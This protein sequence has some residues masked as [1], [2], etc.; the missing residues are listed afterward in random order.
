MGFMDGLESF[1][2]TFLPFRIVD[3][4]EGGVLLRRGKYRRTVGPGLYWTIPFIDSVIA[5]EITP[6]IKDIP[7]I[8][9]MWRGESYVVSGAVEYFIENPKKYA[10]E[11]Q[12]AD[13]TLKN[14]CMAQLVAATEQDVHTMEDFVY[15]KLDRV[16][17]K[18]GI[19]V[20]NFWITKFAKCRVHVLI[21]NEM[22][23]ID[24]D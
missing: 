8:P 15:A 21:G 1:V 9:V 14:F 3:A 23:L 4:N 24:E 12:D 2:E 19:A 7:D 18:W 20:T 22:S 17:E 6:Q 13:V 5:M 16:S 10:I 11:I